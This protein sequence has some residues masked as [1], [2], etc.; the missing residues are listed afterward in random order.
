MGVKKKQ[1]SR[2]EILSQIISEHL[3]WHL[4]SSFVYESCQELG[5]FLNLYINCFENFWYCYRNAFTDRLNICHHLL[6]R[7]ARR[8]CVA[9]KT[10]TQACKEQSCAAIA[11]HSLRLCHWLA[12]FGVLHVLSNSKMNRTTEHLLK[13]L[14][15]TFRPCYQLIT[16][17]VSSAK[18]FFLELAID[19]HGIIGTNIFWVFG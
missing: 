5:I 2:S 10:T 1:F 8:F 3:P 18:W 7:S 12:I 19:G 4:T 17:T 13:K 14:T 15:F 11:I 6:S 16:N 9:V